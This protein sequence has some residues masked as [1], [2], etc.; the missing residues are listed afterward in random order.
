MDGPLDMDFNDLAAL[1]GKWAIVIMM[2]IV[3]IAIM[4]ANLGDVS[5]IGSGFN[6]AE[7]MRIIP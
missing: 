3:I 6:F 2:L 1:V 7:L 5:D 4:F